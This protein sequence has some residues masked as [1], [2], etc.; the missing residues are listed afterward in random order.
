[1]K[2]QERGSLSLLSQGHAGNRHPGKRVDRP[3]QDASSSSA[4]ITSITAHL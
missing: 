1:M 3:H 2:R 4:A